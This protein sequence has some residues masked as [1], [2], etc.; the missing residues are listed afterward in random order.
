MLVWRNQRLEASSLVRVASALG[1]PVD[2][3]FANGLPDE[4]L[5]VEIRKEPGDRF[6]FGG[7]WHSDTSYLARPP[8][9]TLLLAV[10]VP[11]T[12]GD[13]L[14]ADMAGAF[15]GLS[16]G[17]QTTL[18][19]LDGINTSD[20]VHATTGAHAGVAGDRPAPSDASREAVHPVVRRHAVTGRPALYLSAIHT[21]RFAGWTR[22]ESV[23]LID[24][25]QQHATQAE[26]CTRVRWQPGTLTIWDN[27]RVQHYPLNDY[28]GERRVMHRAIVEGERPLAW[29]GSAR[30]TAT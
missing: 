1:T 14:F 19:N 5:V 3:P 2:Y 16:K 26:Y 28:P 21:H 7:A 27:A 24:Y 25:L 4:P 30:R 11:Q 17:M 23:P 8:S 9:A 18:S 13:T 12:G 6:N 20:M 15:A 22:T 29:G 10:E